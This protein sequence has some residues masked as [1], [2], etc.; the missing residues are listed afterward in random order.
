MLRPR[1]TGGTL[2]G[3]VLLLPLDR[4]RVCGGWIVVPATGR[5][6]LVGGE[7]GCELL[8]DPEG[9][10]R[11]VTGPVAGRIP[12]HGRCEHQEETVA[13]RIERWL[14]PPRPSAPRQPVLTSYEFVF[15][16][17]GKVVEQRVWP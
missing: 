8:A 12:G 3:P 9:D 1:A 7:S 10:A 17:T 4:D 13:A 5:R 14:G 16:E 15:D 2:S 6:A 11:A